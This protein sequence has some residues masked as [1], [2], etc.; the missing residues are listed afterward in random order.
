IKN[1]TIMIGKEKIFDIFLNNQVDS[2]VNLYI[3]K[4]EKA[5]PEIIIVDNFYK[6]PDVVR[7]YALSQEL[8]EEKEFYKGKRTK[9]S[10]V[11][12]WIKEEFETLLGKKITEFVG[13]TGIFQYCTSQDALVYHYDLQE[14]A[15][16]VYL[17]PNAPIDT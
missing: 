17:T 16:M 7:N 8:F 12:D 10:Y 14:Y 15:A 6:D 9:K 4:N 5:K 3:Q 1:A 11:P 13:A 2:N